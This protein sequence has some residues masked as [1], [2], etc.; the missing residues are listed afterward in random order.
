[1]NSK[2]K[3]L[4]KF[5]ADVGDELIAKIYREC[6][7]EQMNALL[8]TPPPPPQEALHVPPMPSSEPSMMNMPTP[9]EINKIPELV[10]GPPSSIEPMSQ[11]A[12]TQEIQSKEINAAIAT[13]IIDF[14]KNNEK[15]EDEAIHKFAEEMKINKHEFEEVIY[16]LMG[17][18]LA[19]GKSR[20]FDGEYD[21]KELE[22]GIEVEKEHLIGAKLPDAVINLLAEKIAKDH[23][24]EFKTY[25]TALKNMEK[26][27]EGKK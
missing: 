9:A 15:P 3:E 25:Y 18:F 2:D 24:A 1:M 14:F 16:S 17:A 23:L 27:L 8:Q 26:E 5:I 22:M 11:P 4:N 7:A 19:N 13:N 6:D 12:P 10:F 20:T 21:P